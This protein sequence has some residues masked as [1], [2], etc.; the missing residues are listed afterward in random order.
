MNA[1]RRILGKGRVEDSITGV[2][3]KKYAF[4]TNH[5]QHIHG[6]NTLQKLI[7]QKRNINQTK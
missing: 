7:I 3:S 4:E 2:A 1:I 5:H 6:V